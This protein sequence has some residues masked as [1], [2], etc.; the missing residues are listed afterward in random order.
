M[1]GGGVADCKKHGS[2]Y[3]DFKCRYCC[4][5]SLWFCFGTT[6]FCDRCHTK[7]D[8]KCYPC[9]G[10]A[11]CPLKIEHPKNGTEYALGCGLCR[12]SNI[13]AKDF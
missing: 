13:N 10:P 2:Q 4:S 6:H 11:S 3:I 8:K 9:D 1:V 7:L 12:E 5:V